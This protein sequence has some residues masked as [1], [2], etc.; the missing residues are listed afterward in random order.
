MGMSYWIIDG[1]NGVVVEVAEFEA[2][3]EDAIKHITTFANILADQVIN[4]DIEM[5]G[6]GSSSALQPSFSNKESI[7]NQSC[8]CLQHQI[9]QGGI[10]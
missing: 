7:K 8:T 6:S 2:E 9:T 4:H 10:T 5:G 1:S 3:L